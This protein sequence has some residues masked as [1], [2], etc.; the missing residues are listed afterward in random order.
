MAF[1]FKVSEDDIEEMFALADKDNDGK[2]GF[3]EFQLMINPQKVESNV[4]NVKRKESMKK[5]TIV[6]EKREN[7]LSKEP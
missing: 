4:T 6:T 5:V 7:I 2:I 3:L 1:I